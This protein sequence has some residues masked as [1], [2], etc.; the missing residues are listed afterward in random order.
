MNTEQELS[1]EDIKDMID[2]SGAEYNQGTV[3]A[4]LKAIDDADAQDSQY[5]I[6]RRKQGNRYSE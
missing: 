1:I 6:D 4:M 5:D 2:N 3:M